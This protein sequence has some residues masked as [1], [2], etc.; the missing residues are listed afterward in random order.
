[1]SRNGAPND[2]MLREELGEFGFSDKE[3]DVYLTLLERGEATT[4]AISEDADVTQ[5]AVYTITD[6]LEDRS[7]VHVN[8]HASPK[9]IRAIPPEESMATLASRI[10]SITPVLKDRF[11]DT[12]PRTPELKMVKSQKTAIK[13]LRDAISKAQRE[14]IVAIPEYIYPEIESELQAAAKRDLLVFLLV[15]DVDDLEEARNRYTGAADVVRC[16]SENVLFLFATDTQSKNHQTTQSVLIGD[17][18]LLSGTHDRGDGV[19]V[20]EQHLA[21]SVRG[22][23]FSAYWLAGEEV[24]VTEPDPLPKTFEWFWQAVLHARLHQKSGV[25]LW[26]NIETTDGQTISGTVS[27]IRQALVEPPTNE[28]TLETGLYIETDAGEVSVGGQNTILEDYEAT[29]V[30]LRPN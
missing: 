25:D 8:D 20:S 16:W 22:M 17:A 18:Q 19:A 10:D 24:F 1:M 14:V 23:F 3:I 29:S 21:G 4:G 28:H 13:R 7:L 5:Q 2:E 6:R 27:Q 11:N 26:A 12:E 30:T 9:T 15:Q